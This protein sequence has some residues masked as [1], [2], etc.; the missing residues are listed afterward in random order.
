LTE[1]LSNLFLPLVEGGGASPIA[2]QVSGRIYTVDAN[3]FNI[4]TISLNFSVTGCTINII[5]STGEEAFACGY[6]EWQY[7]QATAFNTA[8]IDG[9]TAIAANG[10]WTADDSFTMVI[11]LYETPF[12]Y[13]FIFHFADDEMMVE[14]RINVSFDAPKTLLL[15]GKAD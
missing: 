3:P 14:T 4:K 9:Q 12:Y 2:Q 5:T 8:D 10:A 7:G 1:K 6:G 11:R 13:R 15:T